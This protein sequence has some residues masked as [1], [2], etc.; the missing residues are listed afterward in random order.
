MSG[1]KIKGTG[2]FVPAK[3]I[4]NEYLSTI[5]DTSDEWITSRT[6]I[7]TRF[8]CT[9]E[10][11]TDMCV[12]AA[13]Q[14]LENAGIKPEEIGACV[15][16][17]F[18]ADY[19]SPSAGCMLQ[20]ELG[21]PHDTVCFDLNAAC[22]GFLFALH[23]M[24]CLLAAAPRKYGL[25]LG[26]EMLSRFINWEDRGTCVLFGDGAGAVVVEW[27]EDYPSIH[28]LL[29]C[30]GDP[31][32][33]GV[34]GA[35]KAEPAR[36]FMH[37]QPTFKFA[38]QAVPYCIDQVLE[39]S[40]KTMDDVDFFVFHQANARIID[41]AVRK[42]HIPPE[43]YYKNI[44]TYGNTSA[45]SIP[46][47]ISELHDLGKVGPGSRILVVGFGGGLTWGGALIEFA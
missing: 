36:I 47:V 46:L 22:S 39:R 20:R 27:R 35:E 28:A 11:H 2:R 23:T 4:T 16:A 6:G 37:G 32:M 31:N 1:I 40:G 29:G 43:K 8:H 42:Y 26:A 13:R 38:V 9:T 3:A 12:G 25:V 19:L 33:L 41:L 24:E 5:V 21:L 44:Q 45:A 7:K 10:T 14:A 34:T 17:T 18:S 15:V 30:H